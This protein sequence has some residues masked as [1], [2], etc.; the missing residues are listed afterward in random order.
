MTEDAELR[1]EAKARAEMKFSFYLNV[2]FYFEIVHRTGDRVQSAGLVSFRSILPFSK[3]STST[4]GMQYV[5]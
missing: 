3:T 5:L 2:A 1:K 4:R